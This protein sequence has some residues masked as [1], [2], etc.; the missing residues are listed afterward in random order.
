[1]ASLSQAEEIARGAQP[2]P[3]RD[4][5]DDIF[6]PKIS[7]SP[8][9][10]TGGAVDADQPPGLASPAGP[11][12][13]P[14]TTERTWEHFSASQLG[15]FLRCPETYRRRY[16]LGQKERPRQALFWGSVDHKTAEHNLRQKIQTESDVPES[17]I[18]D[19][20]DHAWQTK[21]DSE[22]GEGE[23]A[24]D[25]KPGDVKSQ[26]A[27]LVR[28]RHRQ[29]M[30]MIQP[31]AVERE[32]LVTLPQ[33]RLPLKGFIDAETSNQVIDWK[34]TKRAEALSNKPD[35]RLQAMVYAVETGKPV[36]IIQSVKTK[37]PQVDTAKAR[38]EAPSKHQA[39]V[40]AAIVKNAIDQID[41]FTATYGPGRA[42]PTHA[43][44]Y[45]HACGWCGFRPTCFYWGA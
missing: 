31:I 30:P 34:T 26:A 16:V 18:L 6:G 41:Y 17:E 14:T 35:W 8:S 37:V 40:L 44:G 11:V 5:L 23:I 38:I 13:S 29:V 9:S 12:S 20:F 22:G 36:Q 1:M 21:L 3:V 28:I 33:V 25:D 42:W 10:R 7:S 4:P 32:I 15:C 43:P 45:G 27:Q 2:L 24:W 19:A 39:V